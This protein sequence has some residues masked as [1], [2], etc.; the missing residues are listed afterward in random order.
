M[1][2]KKSQTKELPDN[3]T[4]KA[5]DI[6]Q[7]K[8]Y[9][10][11]S[12]LYDHLPGSHKITSPLSSSSPLSIVSSLNPGGKITFQQP[13][14]LCASSYHK[15]MNQILVN[16]QTVQKMAGQNYA[17]EV[18]INEQNSDLSN[19]PM[20]DSCI[21]TPDFPTVTYH[22][23]LSVSG[24]R[25]ISM[26]TSQPASKSNNEINPPL[27][28]T[29]LPMFWNP[30][31]TW[32]SIQPSADN[33]KSFSN[34]E[35]MQ[36]SE[37]WKCP[38]LSSGSKSDVPFIFP[39][40]LLHSPLITLSEYTQS[41]QIIYTT[42]SGSSNVTNHLLPLPSQITATTIPAS[43]VAAPL[44]IQLTNNTTSGLLSLYLRMSANLLMQSAKLY[45]SFILSNQTNHHD[46]YACC[47][48]D[49]NELENEPLNLEYKP[50]NTTSRP[51]YQASSEVL[52]TEP[53]IKAGNSI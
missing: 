22:N 33:S 45:E 14:T 47:S 44:P 46:Q 39:I 31:C 37:F 16:S 38:A 28:N 34:R 32:P 41:N 52:K 35:V 48:P 8:S 6:K 42:A 27:Q 3:T 30:N 23:N 19:L 4:T 50:T 15:Q 21:Y 17:A 2:A 29:F 7:L 20:L 36:N 13:N 9:S 1:N 5:N 12:G 18:S 11:K 43:T 49:S 40:T 24:K 26:S 10:D 25:H 53:D 51:D